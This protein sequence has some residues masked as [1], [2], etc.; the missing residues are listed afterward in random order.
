MENYNS[1]ICSC[2]NLSKE[3]VEVFDQK[4]IWHPYTSMLNP[5]PA[6]QVVK[7]E[8]VYLYLRNGQK[9]I[10]GMSSWWSAI[11]GYNVPEL[12]EAI[13]K[14]L[15][16][17][18]HVMFG[19]LTHE[20]AVKLSKLLIGITPESLKHIFLSDSGSVSVEVALKMAIQYWAGKGK[21]EKV[22][23]L[24]IE[25]GY[26]GDTW[27]AMSVC[28]PVTGMH[29]LF[30]KSLP[31]N[32]FAKRPSS[33]FGYKFNPRDL[34]SIKERVKKHN[35][36]LA[37]IIVEPVVQ[38]AG[39]MWFYHP[40]YLNELRKICDEYETLLIFD[41]I[42]TG[43]GRTG[44]L[45]ATNYTS[46]TPDIMTLAK[47][48]TG[49]YLTLGATLTTTEVA[50][51]ISLSKASCFMHGPTYMGNPLACAVAY[52]NI[53]LLLESDWQ[54][55]VKKIETILKRE[56]SEIGQSSAIADVRVLGAIGVVEMQ[57]RVNVSKIQKFFVK[58]GVWI[59][60]FGKNIYI[61]PPYVI[62]ED[63]LIKLCHAI[64]SAVK[65]GIWQ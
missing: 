55:K 10:D 26:H 61:M 13:S 2:D 5:L 39:G 31:Q 34:E 12:N 47:T 28:D 23:F 30:S 58:K 40:E 32:F 65:K 3:E 27:H 50:H 14:Q 6:Y 24:T 29:E 1:L 49:G 38:G 8:G 52:A 19:G 44:E 25:N 54:S 42:A 53:K 57:E 18:A 17:M 15:Q 33:R 9:L 46:I 7:A 48:L 11:H 20:P 56:L 35:K 36:K 4:H 63:E 41:E 16:K 51:S 59:R 62:K 60:P 64:K 22:K 43:L 21:P 37:A 45:F